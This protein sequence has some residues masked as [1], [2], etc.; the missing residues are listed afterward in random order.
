MVFFGMLR[1]VALVRIDVSEELSASIIR[2]T[3]IGELGTTLAVNSN[4]HTLRRNTASP[5]LVTLMKEGLRSS[6]TSIHTRATRHNISED[7]ILHSHRRENLK[8][9]KGVFMCLRHLD[10]IGEPS[11]LEC[12]PIL[13]LVTRSTRC[14]LSASVLIYLKLYKTWCSYNEFYTEIMTSE[15]S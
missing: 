12:C 10:I 9:Y 8:S 11:I 6:E 14:S 2:A 15:T 7:A 5:I 4:R 3:R 13:K 1:C